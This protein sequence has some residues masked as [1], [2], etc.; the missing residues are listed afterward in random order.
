MCVHQGPNDR[1]DPSSPA[2]V[3]LQ[4]HVE[5]MVQLLDSVGQS[6]TSGDEAQRSDECVQAACGLA[7]DLLTTF[8]VGVLPLLN[9]GNIS[10]LLKRARHSRQSKTKQLAQW[11]WREMKKL[12][13]QF[14]PATA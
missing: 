6:Y 12:E 3:W 11:T 8:G 5:S 13:K 7:G 9:R 10:E 2:L 1:G 4:P 14:Q